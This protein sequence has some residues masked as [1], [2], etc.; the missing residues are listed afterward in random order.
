MAIRGYLVFIPFGS[1]A[2]MEFGAPGDDTVM[3][4]RTTGQLAGPF[5]V[6]QVIADKLVMQPCGPVANEMRRRLGVTGE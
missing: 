5:E 1:V 3:V 6:V 2:S 4:A